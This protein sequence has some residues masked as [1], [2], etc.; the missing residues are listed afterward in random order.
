MST[1]FLPLFPLQLVVFPGEPLN[2]HIFEPR[3]R[4]LIAE[5]EQEGKTFGIPAVLNGKLQEIGTEVKLLSVE[6]RYADGKLDIKTQG[7]G[8]FKIEEFFTKAPDKLYGG[9]E[10]LSLEFTTGG[11][12]VLSARIIEKLKKLYGLLKVNK[13]IPE[14]PAE[15]STFDFAHHVG[16][17]VDQ[18][19]EFLSI[20]TEMDR[21]TYMEA[22]LDR[23]IPMV[24]DMEALRERV[25]MNGH[26]KN[27]IPPNIKEF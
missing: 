14:D 2:L 12:I 17:S 18:E 21:Q 16:F 25:R 10:I 5:C 26:F 22:H 4:Q 15:F 24:A 27:V 8:I 1:R 7:I 20:P 23:F 19:Y 6:K 9:A 11:D 13:A 3:Y